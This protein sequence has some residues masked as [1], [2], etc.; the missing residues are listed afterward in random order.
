[1]VPFHNLDR[2]VDILNSKFENIFLKSPI[3]K[4]S[5]G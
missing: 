3:L 1:M 4:H 5:Y 2:Y